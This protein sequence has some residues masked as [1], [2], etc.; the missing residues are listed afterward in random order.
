MNLRRLCS[1]CSGSDGYIVT[2]NGQD[3]VRCAE[4]DDYQYCAPRVETGREV[5]SLSTRP[6]LKPAVRFRILDEFGYV[7][8]SCGRGAPE[9]ELTVDHIISRKAAEMAGVL[10]DLIDSDDNL[11]PMCAPCNSGKRAAFTVGTIKLMHRALIM[12]RNLGGGEAA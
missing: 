2:K 4:C 12:R 8:I 7:C 1:S 10:D 5:R 9:V 6:N 11:A 3:V